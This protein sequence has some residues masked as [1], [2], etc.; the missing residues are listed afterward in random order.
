M[1]KV[2]IKLSSDKTERSN[3][4]KPAEVCDDFFGFQGIM[5]TLYEFYIDDMIALLRTKNL[6]ESKLINESPFIRL[7]LLCA[8]LLSLMLFGLQKI[9]LSVPNPGSDGRQNIG[10]AYNIAQYGVFSYLDADDGK[11]MPTHHREPVYSFLLAGVMRIAMDWHEGI[12]QA[13]FLEQE[14]ICTPAY[15]TIKMLHVLIALLIALSTYFI[16]QSFLKNAILSLTAAAA[17]GFV[18]CTSHFVNRFYTDHLAALFLLLHSYFLAVLVRDKKWWM[19]CL[20]GLLLGLL[21]LTKAVFFYWLI[22]LSVG[23]PLLTLFKPV[24]W[25][26]KWIGSFV[27]LLLVSWLAVGAWMTRNA[28][29]VGDFSVSKRAG[30]LLAIRAEFTTMSWEDYFLG[31]IYFNPVL[32]RLSSSFIDEERY[33]NFYRNNPEGYYRRS[34]LGLGATEQW[35]VETGLVITDENKQRAAVTVIKNNLTMQIALVPFFA[36]RGIFIKRYAF[37]FFLFLGLFITTIIGIK[38]RNVMLIFTLPAWYSY[39]MHAGL[40]HYIPRYS[41]PLL[42]VLVVCFF[43]VVSVLLAKIKRHSDSEPLMLDSEN[44]R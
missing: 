22:L 5:A 7:S 32:K 1:V 8:I 36:Q 13:C 24:L 23:L 11:V 35:M 6:L 38:R 37:S 10:A 12:K 18:F 26:K 25:Q 19:G 2:A 21:V 28:V 42:P 34:K 43:Y 17:V 16:A 31:L 29:Q 44:A 3:R 30:E 15:K 41:E 9:N 27:L 4:D 39:F 20:C 14:T 40:T 33:T